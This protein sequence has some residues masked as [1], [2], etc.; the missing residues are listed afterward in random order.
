LD[1]FKEALENSI[2]MDLVLVSFPDSQRTQ[3][4]RLRRSVGD[5]PVS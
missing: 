5:H 1:G 2:G 3:R 4:K